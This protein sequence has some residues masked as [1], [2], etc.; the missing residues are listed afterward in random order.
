MTLSSTL[1]KTIHLSF[2]LG[3]TRFSSTA[4]LD[5]FL[6]NYPTPGMLVWAQQE[7]EVYIR[8][9][10]CYRLSLRWG[11][12]MQEIYQRISYA[13]LWLVRKLNGLFRER[14]VVALSKKEE[15]KLLNG[16]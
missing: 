9:R 2:A 4:I 6:R 13:P 5:T 1:N 12:R 10:E 8:R 7:K 14:R 16:R 11:Y 3:Y 15:P